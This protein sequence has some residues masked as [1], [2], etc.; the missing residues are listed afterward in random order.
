MNRKAEDEKVARH[1]GRARREPRRRG[2]RLKA[3][4]GAFAAVAAALVAVAVAIGASPAQACDVQGGDLTVRAPKPQRITDRLHLEWTTV[5]VLGDRPIWYYRVEMRPSGGTWVVIEGELDEPDRDRPDNQ[6][7]IDGVRQ[8]HIPQP[9]DPFDGA[10]AWGHAYT[11]YGLPPGAERQFRVTAWHDESPRRWGTVSDTVTGTTNGTGGSGPRFLEASIPAAGTTIVTEWEM[12][13]SRTLRGTAPKPYRFQ[14]RADGEKVTVS[15]ASVQT[16][17]DTVTLTL[18]STIYDDQRVEVSY[19]D[20]LER[21]D[22]AGIVVEDNHGADASDFT[23]QVAKNNSTQNAP[24]APPEPLTAEWKSSPDA[25]DGSSAFE[26]QL[27]FSDDIKNT[28]SYV[29]DAITVTGGTVGSASRVDGSSSLW[30]LT[31]TPSGD[32]AVTLTVNS[33]G[34]CPSTADSAVLCTSDGRTL[35]NS[36]SVTVAG[37]QPVLT[38]EWVDYPSEGHAGSGTFEVRL[39]FSEPIKNSYRYVDDAITATRGTVNWAKRVDG[40]SDLWR[41]EVAPSG[42]GA[43]KLTVNGGGTCPEDDQSSVLCTSA[44]DVLGNSPSVTI[45]GPRSLSVAD[46]SVREASGATVDFVVTLSR[47]AITDITVE[48]ETESG[49]ATQGEDFTETTGTLTFSITEKTKTVSVPI[50]D[51][52]VDEGNETFTLRLKNPSGAYLSDATATGT[53]VN[54]DP[55][56]R[57]WGLRFARTIAFQAWDA[58]GKRKL[59]GSGEHL[60]VAGQRLVATGG[61]GAHD[62]A[63]TALERHADPWD[64]DDLRTHGMTMRDALLRTSF[65]AGG[66]GGDGRPGW[67]AWGEFVLGSFEA[68]VDGVGMEGGVTTA[69]LGADAGNGQWLAGAMVSV[70]DGDGPFSMTNAG[71]SDQGAGTIEGS[72]TALYPYAK[73]RLGDRVEAS[74]VAGMGEGDLTI[75]QDGSAPLETGMSMRMGAVG[76]AGDILRA[77]DGAAIDLRAKTDALWVGMETGALRSGAGNLAA[78]DGDATRL[79]LVLEGS[80]VFAMEGERSFAPSLSLG[81]RHDGGDAERGFGVEA[82]G[83]VRLAWPGVA[84]DGRLRALVAHEEAGYEEWGASGSIRI[85]PGASGRGLSLSLSPTW[86]KPGSG[87]ERLWSLDNAGG[88]D[89]GEFEAGKRLEAELGY[90]LGG[91]CG[92]GVVTPYAGASWAGK[93]GGTVRAGASWQLAP[94]ALL[95]FEAA[96]SEAG[97]ASPGI[98][99]ILLRARF[100]W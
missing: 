98:S 48:Y 80:R 52:S 63:S 19:S 78:A 38:A 86:G 24:M 58:V 37:P 81:L 31:V 74:A 61:A 8:G 47:A 68:E 75:K 59:G 91:P 96:R 15:S 95:G 4:F 23:W 2:S 25:H 53:I 45:Q 41:L 13:G 10:P 22:P 88:F 35:S 12:S 62:P 72:M 70:S 92:V 69:M 79:R 73:L 7:Y 11:V 44:G 50:I 65:S 43:V 55:L 71:P 77:S 33:G 83:G 97:G 5:C 21:N 40:R 9:E 76:L 84:V 39:G 34:T 32:D 3:R 57:A 1:T 54:S 20:N 90:G 28:P 16:G 36:P 93:G 29:D 46:A 87:T 67:G 49:T 17:D 99:A 42:N 82:G 94:Q 18:G 27:E 89:Q 14:V 100:R 66:G 64:E 56:Q 60:T 51:D 6:A 30:K 26:V 85:D